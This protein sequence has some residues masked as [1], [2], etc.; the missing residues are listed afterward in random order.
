MF[1][2]IELKIEKEEGR[3]SVIEN[4]VRKECFHFVVSLERSW[5]FPFIRIQCHIKD[6]NTV[7]TSL[8][9]FNAPPTSFEFVWSP[10]EK[11]NKKIKIPAH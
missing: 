1:L 11:K 8:N 9:S 2:F 6:F 4:F 3:S 5:V 7:V 10:K